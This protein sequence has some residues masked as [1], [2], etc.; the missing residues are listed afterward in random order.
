M[1]QTGGG[2]ATSVADCKCFLWL[3]GAVNPHYGASSS[4]Y[5]NIFAAFGFFYISQIVLSDTLK[6]TGIFFDLS[7]FLQGHKATKT[8]KKSLI[9]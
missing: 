7:T 5:T 4:S 8:L 9:K 6:I 2:V 3:R 1:Q